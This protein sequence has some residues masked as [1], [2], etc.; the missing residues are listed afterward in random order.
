LGLNTFR[1][2]LV[3]TF[4]GELSSH[5]VS[6]LKRSVGRKGSVRSEEGSV[7]IASALAASRPLEDH[8]GVIR[9]ALRS[10]VMQSRLKG[11]D[12]SVRVQVGVGLH[13]DQ[14]ALTIETPFLPELPD[15][16]VSLWFTIYRLG[17]ADA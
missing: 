11:R 3:V 9:V 7:A 13:E 8:L 17:T 2:S 1:V 10:S 15:S 12:V 16:P 4:E 14:A 5:E 6:E